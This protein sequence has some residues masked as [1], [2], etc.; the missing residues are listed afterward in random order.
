MEKKKYL[1]KL[2]QKLD[3]KNPDIRLS[4]RIIFTGEVKDPLNYIKNA[5]MIIIP[6]LWEGLPRVAI[7]ATSF[8]NSHN[9]IL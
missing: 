9:F 5:K 4:S 6:S 7:E 3:K 8:K 1:K 2:V